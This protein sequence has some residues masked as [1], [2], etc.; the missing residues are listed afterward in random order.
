MT[1]MT[2]EEYDEKRHK[3]YLRLVAAAE[4]ATRESASSLQQAH[5]MASV[6]PFG[7]PILVGHYSESADRNYRARIE[8]KYRKGFDLHEKAARLRARAEAMEHNTTIFSDDPR[9]AEK[10]E[11]RIAQLEERQALMVA[12][13]KLVKKND[14]AGLA[15]LGFSDARIDSLMTPDFVGRTGFPAFELANNRSNINRLKDRQKVIERHAQDETSEQQIGDVTL[16]DNVEE[17]RLQIKFPSKP[18]E[19]I[20]KMLKA[21]GFHFTHEGL[22][23]RMRSADAMYWAQQIIAKYHTG[24]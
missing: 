5:N 20:R 11:E 2:P 23:Q 21:H 18:A 15:A 6:I 13:N 22:W 17:N 12:A 7:Q 8:G 16:T 1:T 9:A 24:G 14:R 10:I 19:E 4:R 3:R